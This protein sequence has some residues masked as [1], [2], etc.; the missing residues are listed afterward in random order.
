VFKKSF[1]IKIA[2]FET[3]NEKYAYQEGIYVGVC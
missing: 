1:S 2:A 3:E